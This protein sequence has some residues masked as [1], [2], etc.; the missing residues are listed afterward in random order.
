[1]RRHGDEREDTMMEPVAPE[2]YPETYSVE[3]TIVLTG[4]SA[5]QLARYERARLVLPLRAG[6]RSYY[7]AADVRRI[8]KVRRLQRDLGINLAGIE[9][10]LR[11]TEQL[12]DLRQRLAAYESGGEA[13][14]AEDEKQGS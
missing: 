11:L 7:R 9:V 1:M 2:T 13:P 8:R 14:P 5:V 3:T 6:G 4:V 10:V 12:D